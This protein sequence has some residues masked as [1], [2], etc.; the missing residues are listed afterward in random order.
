M[1]SSCSCCASVIY[2]SEPVSTAV[3]SIKISPFQKPSGEEAWRD[4]SPWSKMFIARSASPLFTNNSPWLG[5]FVYIYIYIYIS[6]SDRFHPFHN[7]GHWINYHMFNLIPVHIFISHG[8]M[9]VTLVSSLLCFV[10][11]VVC[12]SFVLLGEVVLNEKETTC[13]LNKG[14]PMWFTFTVG[15]NSSVRLAA[16]NAFQRGWPTRQTPNSNVQQ[17]PYIHTWSPIITAGEQALGFLFSLNGPI[18][19]IWSYTTTVATA[20]ASADLLQRYG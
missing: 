11:V 4:V 7:W 14:L 19:E 18:S 2:R 6:G 20:S 10:F 8:C 16:G 17:E 15:W 5:A 3:G 12:I 9:E 1:D 13:W